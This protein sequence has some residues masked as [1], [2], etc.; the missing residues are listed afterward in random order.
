MRAV[1]Y[2]PD[3]LRQILMDFRQFKDGGRLGRKGYNIWRH[4][5]IY[6][7]DIFYRTIQDLMK[8]KGIQYFGDLRDPE[9]EDPK[10]RYKLK[11]FT[12]DVTMARLV[13]LPDDAMLYGLQPDYIEIAWA[14]RAS[15]SIPYFFRPVKLGESYFV[16]G[17]LLSN[18]PIWTWDSTSTPPW[19]TFGVVLE[20][21]DSTKGHRITGNVSFLEAMFNTV[22]KAHDR[23]FIRPADF[24]HRTIKVPVG[25]VKATDFDLTA[26][27]KNWLYHN[28]VQAGLTF[29]KNWSW[30]EYVKWSQTERGIR[31]VGSSSR[32]R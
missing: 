21:E 22:L 20:E 13:S 19:P 17:G 16:D 18:Y 5:G 7:G 11:V 32:M 25:D 26:D 23:R 27:R 4:K 6:K 3:E 31:T 10:F 9:Q 28:G 24:K 1:G 2:I 12:A 8:A 29:M 30:D 15:M 14:V